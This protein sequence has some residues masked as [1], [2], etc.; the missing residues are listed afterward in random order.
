MSN[1]LS[2]Y[3]CLGSNCGDSEQNLKTAIEHLKT[4]EKTTVGEVSSVYMT[5]P[6]GDKDQD[7]FLNQMVRL[8]YKEPLPEDFNPVMEGHKLLYFLLQVEQTMGRV[9]DSERRFGPRTIDLD[10][11][12]FNDVVI[13]NDTLQIPH[14]RMKERAFVL[15]PLKEI[16]PNV[17]IGGQSLDELLSAIDYKLEGNKIYQK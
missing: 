7:W 13:D 16:A 11:V 6:Q 2:I 12:Y 3:I 1:P 15:L 17:C 9:R 5:E 10:I 14:A 8:D 4:Y